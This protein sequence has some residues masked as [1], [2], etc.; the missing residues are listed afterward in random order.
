MEIGWQKK[1]SPNV[2]FASKNEGKQKILR[3]EKIESLKNNNVNYINN[4]KK[5][6]NQG[7]IKDKINNDNE[8]NKLIAAN[9]IIQSCSK[10]LN[11]VDIKNGNNNSISKKISK[12]EL[13]DIQRENLYNTI[14]VKNIKYRDLSYNPKNEVS[15][16]ENYKFFED[17]EIYDN[18]LYMPKDNLSFKIE[19][20]ENNSIFN[21]IISRFKKFNENY[22]KFIKHTTESSLFNY[23]IKKKL[24]N[25]SIDMT[26]VD[27]N[28]KN[29]L[30]LNFEQENKKIKIIKV[31][32]ME[33]NK[34]KKNITNNIFNHSMK[35][36]N[37][38][39][40]KA[41]K[42]IINSKEVSIKNNSNYN[43]E[44]K[45]ILSISNEF[46]LKK[47][48][49]RRNI[50]NKC[51]KIKEKIIIHNKYNSLTFDK[52]NE[53]INYIPINSR[54]NYVKMPIKQNKFPAKNSKRKS[55]LKSI[56]IIHRPIKLDSKYSDQAEKT[57]PIY[58]KTILMNKVNI[59]NRIN[60]HS[61]Y[62]NI[63]LPKENIL[64]EKST[65]ENNKKQY[66]ENSKF[67]NTN[68]SINYNCFP[69]IN[70]NSEYENLSSNG[71]TQ[72][73]SD[74][75][76]K[77]TN[78]LYRVKELEKIVPLNFL[79]KKD[80][81]KITDNHNY[82]D[83]NNSFLE[84]YKNN[85]LRNERDKIDLYIKPLKSK[86]RDK[87]YE[88]NF[89]KEKLLYKKKNNINNLTSRQTFILN[90]SIEESNNIVKFNYIKKP[91]KKHNTRFK[92]IDK[93]EEHSEI[94]T[95]INNT[96]STTKKIINIINDIKLKNVSFEENN[97]LIIQKDYSFGRYKRY[98][99]Y[100]I[101]LPIKQE[102]F[103]RKI[104]RKKSNK[105]YNELPN[106]KCNGYQIA[107]NQRKNMSLD[108][109][110]NGNDNVREENFNNS[111]SKKNYNI[112]NEN[113]NDRVEY[114]CINKL[115]NTFVNQD[116][117]SKR[118]AITEENFTLGCSKLNKILL[119]NSKITKLLNGFGLDSIDSQIKVNSQEILVQNNELNNINNDEKANGGIERYDKNNYLNIKQFDKKNSIISK[120]LNSQLTGLMKNV[121]IKAKESNIL[122]K[123]QVNE[124]NNVQIPINSKT[125]EYFYN[126]NPIT[127]IKNKKKANSSNNVNILNQMT[128][129]I[130]EIIIDKNVY[131]QIFKDLQEYLKFSEK[132]Q[133]EDNKTTNIHYSYNWKTIDDLMLA[134][135]TKLEEVIKIFVEICKNQNFSKER[136][137]KVYNYIKTIIE[138]YISDFTKIQIEIVHL[139]M[140]ELFKNVFEIDSN[141][142]NN[143]SEIL[144]NLLFT[145]LKYKL[146]FMKDLNNFIEKK[147]EIQINIAKVV[148]YSILA[149]GKYLKQ[150]HNDFKFTK[151][152]NNNDIF[153]NYVTR[154]IQELRKKI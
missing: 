10:K 2:N 117:K 24:N 122:L 139:N 54:N 48:K 86:S 22:Q 38:E 89:S 33:R 149:S 85:T 74:F 108:F 45:D 42:K 123:T 128:D 53:T 90:N 91:L 115:K 118:N 134:G 135:K 82:K 110:K 152:F 27:N 5:V 43:L 100:Y 129:G 8:K 124:I 41:N 7:K 50:K 9:K 57:K 151:F 106:N 30:K 40:N 88:T 26:A 15:Y 32:H 14:N 119:K 140:I 70:T 94:N 20:N 56:E 35:T 147:K 13:L 34:K 39:K 92:K 141:I 126:M 127:K 113:F 120:N 83:D 55:N 44:K 67:F 36:M 154:E 81:I 65:V 145:L 51:S 19:L 23:N 71:F 84:K 3:V 68:P 121:D 146:F 144:G 153:V 25:N 80:Y 47:I 61:T 98:Y 11:N 72:I 77:N 99:N 103:I 104:K 69:E 63:A 52:N 37:K 16:T 97:I 101:K 116:I 93:N 18:K 62:R 133:N 59:Y 148:K 96:T 58:N 130:R 111:F 31:N 64:N 4:N 114:F 107:I 137:P 132:R 76:E 28:Q 79:Q 12:N 109:I 60:N 6:K 102:C 136:I 46:L 78:N 73:P 138:Y 125:E 17:K 143:F 75:Y 66:T 142:S 95:N 131:E 105:K 87:K 112:I 29:N 49:S 1:Y 21:Q 150:Y